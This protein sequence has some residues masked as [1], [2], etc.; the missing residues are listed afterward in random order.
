MKCSDCIG[1][2]NVIE[3]EGISNMVMRIN[4]DELSSERLQQLSMG[5]KK[6]PS[7]VI[8]SEN[9]NPIICDG[10]QECSNWLNNFT[11]NRRKTLADTLTERRKIMQREISAARGNGPVEYSEAEMAGTSDDY[12]YM[13]T[14]MA[15]LKNYIPIGQEH[16]FNIIT[17]KNREN[18]MTDMEMKNTMSEQTRQREN[19][20]NNMKTEMEKN[21]IAAVLSRNCVQ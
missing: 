8:N 10:P 5:I 1:L 6:I 3:N 15:Q 11:L 20:N 4:L 9:N 2:L 19:D 21:Q 7:I 14:D 17:I 18:K 16:S 12:A 13:E